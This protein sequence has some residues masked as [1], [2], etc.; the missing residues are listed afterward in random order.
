MSKGRLARRTEARSRRRRM[1]L[2]GG[3]VLAGIAVI[4]GALALGI[5]WLSSQRDAG[6]HGA[7]AA[8]EERPQAQGADGTGSAAKVATASAP[9][10]DTPALLAEDAGITFTVCI[11]PGHQAKANLEGEPIGPGATEKKP[12]VTGGATGTST[13]QPE[14]DVVLAIA[15]VLRERLEAQGVRV[16]MTRT[17]ASVDISNAERATMANEAAVDLFVR[18]HAD[19]NTDSSVRG[20]STLYPG[21]NE[22]VAG[23]EEESRTAAEALHRAVVKA[24]SARDRGIVQ[25][26]DLSGFNWATVPSVLVECGFLSNPDEDRLLADAEYREKVAEGLAEGIEAYLDGR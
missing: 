7:I 2:I 3:A 21:G 12:K 18:I 13:G 6:G 10:A 20:I 19:G 14:H 8:A 9:A 25:R 15:V 17:A 24:T 23:I 5:G 26:A 16:V 11:D 22:W 1:T 4:A